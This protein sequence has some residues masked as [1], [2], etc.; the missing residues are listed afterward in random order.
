MDFQEVSAFAA[1]VEKI[2]SSVVLKKKQAVMP[3]EV[4]NEH[5]KSG[6]EVEGVFCWPAELTANIFL[7][8]RSYHYKEKYIAFLSAYWVV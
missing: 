6:G 5:C 7:R 2:S 1:T 4:S 3:F 8:S